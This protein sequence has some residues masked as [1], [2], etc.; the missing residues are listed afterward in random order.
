MKNILKALHAY[1]VIAAGLVVLMAVALAATTVVQIFVKGD[2]AIDFFEPATLATMRD[3]CAVALRWLVPFAVMPLLVI[4]P[5]ARVLFGGYLGCG[6]VSA[7]GMAFLCASIGAGAY[8]IK[9]LHSALVRHL[10]ATDM[11]LFERI[12]LLPRDLVCSG[13]LASYARALCADMNIHETRLQIA[14]IVV[15]VV[16]LG[17]FIVKVKTSSCAKALGLG[18]IGTGCFLSLMAGAYCFDLFPAILGRAKQEYVSAFRLDHFWAE[19]VPEAMLWIMILALAVFFAGMVCESVCC[20][21][22]VIG[23]MI[24]LLWGVTTGGIAVV[25]A[26]TMFVVGFFA[27]VILANVVC[28]VIFIVV[29][30][31]IVKVMWGGW[32]S[33]M[34]A[35]SSSYDSSSS[36]ASASSSSRESGE[37]ITT[38]TDSDGCD[39]V[40][41]GSCPDVIEKQTPG[42]YAKFD[43]QFDGSYK[44]RFGDRTLA[45]P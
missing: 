16:F 11:T 7:A 43:R 4:L 30:S 15:E 34:N 38:I 1:V 37:I 42:D 22:S 6:K 10:P 19:T 26:I 33:S 35:P 2:G 5:L 32:E 29:G 18:S 3:W 44:E 36:S 23:K 45:E 13:V 40:G 12:A 24:G 17:V 28:I 27:V 14:L 21:R 9:L 8:A 25:G 41:K 31:I 39:Y 20:K